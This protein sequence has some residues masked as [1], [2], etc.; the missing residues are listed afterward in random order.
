M[1]IEGGQTCSN[2]QPTVWYDVLFLVLDYLK[3]HEFNQVWTF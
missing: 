2:L 3:I 1:F